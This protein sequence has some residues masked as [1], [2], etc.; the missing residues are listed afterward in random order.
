[1]KGVATTEA[2]VSHGEGPSRLTA[3]ADSGDLEDWRRRRESNPPTQ[4]IIETNSVF[5]IR[6]KFSVVPL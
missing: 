1:M 2:W 6:M 5:P 3:V 4:P